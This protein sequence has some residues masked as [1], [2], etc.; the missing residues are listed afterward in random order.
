MK[1]KDGI[2]ISPEEFHEKTMEY[3]S[4]HC[5]YA[6]VLK[7]NSEKGFIPVGFMYGIEC[8]KYI[9]IISI[10]WFDW[11]S[12]RNKLET[13]LKFIVVNQKSRVFAR[14]SDKDEKRFHQRL[15]Q[16]GVLHRVGTFEDIDDEKTPFYQTRLKRNGIKS[17]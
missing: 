15:C 7:A 3:I 16:Y 12:V 8:D 9:N 1:L 5:D 10:D 11:A 13:V 4:T 17:K 14:L 2:E 6:W